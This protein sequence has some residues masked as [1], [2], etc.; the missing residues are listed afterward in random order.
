M[1][2][3]VSFLLSI[4]NLVIAIIIYIS[5]HGWLVAYEQSGMQL[6]LHILIT[7]PVTI[8][9]T[10]WFF[11]LSSQNKI[12]TNFW[13]VNAIGILIPIMSSQTGVTYYHYD[14]VGLFIAVVILIIIIYFLIKEIRY[15]RYGIGN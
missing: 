5:L 3:I 11:Y 13:K 8:I 4:V 6:I 7:A 9:T 14:L 12:S 15:Y 2:I 10:I 1:S